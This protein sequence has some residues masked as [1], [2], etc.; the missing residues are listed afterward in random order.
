M[1]NELDWM[2]NEAVFMY[3]SRILLGLRIHIGTQDSRILTGV[4][5]TRPTP[6]G[7]VNVKLSDGRSQVPFSSEMMSQFV[8]DVNYLLLH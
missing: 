1:N 7:H 4:L 2:W 5:A 8:T 6:Y 3:D